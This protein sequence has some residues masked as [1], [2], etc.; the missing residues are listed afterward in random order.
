MVTAEQNRL[1]LR[2]AERLAANQLGVNPDD[3]ALNYAQRQEFNH[4]L[5]AI[6]LQYPDRFTD[7]TL[8]TARGVAG[9]TYEPL[10]DASFS[11]ADFVS[12]YVEP[13]A[14]AGRGTASAIASLKW[15][16]PVALV[17]VVG[18]LLLGLKKKVAG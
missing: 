8:E 12:A 13:I 4:A 15:L 7:A 10:Q 5:A 18:I 6:I 1:N 17:V 16:I 2:S 3:N 11:A 9:R 14:E